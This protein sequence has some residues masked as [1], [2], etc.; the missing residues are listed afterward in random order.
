MEER[1]RELTA[2]LEVS[3]SLS[4]TLALEPLL[5][6]ILDR[7]LGVIDYRGASIIVVRDDMLETVASRNTRETVAVRSELGYTVPLA[8]ALPIWQ[9]AHRGEPVVIRDVRGDDLF[10]RTW[11]AVR[12]GAAGSLVRSWLGVP[13][14]SRG[15]VFG[16]LALTRD[17]PDSFN[18]H[19]I[20]LAMAFAGHAAVAIDNARLYERE[21]RAA[22]EL[23]TLLGVARSAASTLELEPLLNNILDTLELVV[24][25]AGASIGVVDGDEF[26]FL[27]A[28]GASSA[29]R[30]PEMIGVRL[31][32]RDNSGLWEPL[33]RHE[34]VIIADV[35][36]D[37]TAAHAFRRTVGAYYDSRAMRDVRAFMIIP[38]VNRDR[39][40]G[41]LTM[42]SQVRGVFTER[43]AGLAMA[44]ATHIAAALENARL[45]DQ[46]EQRAHELAALL[47][48]SQ[49]LTST[50]E[51]ESLLDVLCDQLYMVANYT[52]CAILVVDGDKV[53][54]LAYRGPVP[55]EVALKRSINIDRRSLFWQASAR[56]EPVIIDDI[57]DDTPFAR[58]YRQEREG[59]LPPAATYHVRS[60]L[61]VPL[62]HKD[63]AIGA[64][65]I[66]HD[67][68]HYYTPHHAE[69]ATGI[70]TQA[71]AA[72]ENARLY[73]QV[74]QRARELTTLLEVSHAVTSTLELGP[75]LDLILEQLKTVVDYRG[76]TL[77][78]IDGEELLIVA[79]RAV[80]PERSSDRGLRFPLL[81]FGPIWEAISRGEPAIIADVRG[82]EP[83]AVEYRALN[84]ATMDGPT[85]RD[86]RSWMAVPLA[87]GDRV[88][89]MLSASQDVPNYFTPHHAELALAFANQVTVAVEN[90]RLFAETQGKAALEER[91]RLARELHD[92]VS[93]ALFG[94]ALGAGAARR[95]LDLDPSRV[96]ESIDYVLSLADV[97]L[98]EMR[99]L[100][101][102]LRPEA[103][104]KDGLVAAL[105]RHAAATRA[106]H[107]VTV[108]SVFCEEPDV[109]LATKEALYRI[110]QE[111]M[112]NAVK[113]ARASRIDLILSNTSTSV[114]VEV[115][116][117]GVG[118][119]PS[120]D[121]AGHLGLHS[122][123]ERMAVVGGTTIIT[124]AP[125]QG[126]SIRAT[127]PA[128]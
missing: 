85:H 94:I 125:G 59:D 8:R 66:T 127:V 75:L 81:R 44:I 79:S 114:S 106:R 117:D 5:D 54:P 63:E 105:T 115:R 27:E 19:D 13:L 36:D 116:D 124:S 65:A 110:A 33:Y 2:L 7:L 4:S 87:L 91:Q 64:I 35:R 100:I 40:V 17:E 43:H 74:E 11:R 18:G 101:F 112:H 95:R 49:N 15:Q 23:A 48:A 69:L 102:E 71:A 70:A 77:G 60:W 41:L 121:F 9:A 47:G 25:Y 1:T 88:I 14:S 21:R 16:F 118:F 128:P 3:R 120:Q 83:A 53:R 58:A 20:E 90:A 104:E 34:P 10:A 37:S 56:R 123:R 109:P 42:S 57:F 80:T 99:S 97:A 45:Y 26:R 68:P 39:L 93:Q 50:L 72:I 126:A 111:A 61:S 76:A 119:D 73:A 113:H 46:T 62:I 51:L 107:E 29:E 22:Q 31:P 12:S 122:M 52:S 103:L 86:I 89:G 82:D 30:R 92:S 6:L 24:D 96:G 32:M 108:E 78:T 84:A 38:L 67:T 98:T 28:R 55:T